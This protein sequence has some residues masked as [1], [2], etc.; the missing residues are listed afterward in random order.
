MH[1][2][3]A[4]LTMGLSWSEVVGIEPLDNAMDWLD[5]L[6]DTDTGVNKSLEASQKGNSSLHNFCGSHRSYLTEKAILVSLKLINP[7]QS[8]ARTAILRRKHVFHIAC[9]ISR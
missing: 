8:I 4:K 5:L 9:Y 3:A 2:K 6:W 1:T 7:F